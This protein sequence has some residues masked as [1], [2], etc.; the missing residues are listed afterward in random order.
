MDHFEGKSPIEHL[1][2]ARMKTKQKLKENHAVE[3]KSYLDAMIRLMS[4][5]AMFF[6]LLAIFDLFFPLKP[7][8]IFL[9]LAAFVFFRSI[10]CSLDAT[11]RLE[12]L[13]RVIKEERYE[14]E[15][16]EAQ[17]KEELKVM[18]A[19]KGFQGKLLDDVVAVLMADQ[20]RL[21][22]V[23]LEEELGLK[24]ESFEHPLLQGL[25]ALTGGLI[26][27][28]ILQLAII[29]LPL[30]FAIG[31]GGFFIGFS[32]Y[33]K[34][35]IEKISRLKTTVWHLANFLLVVSLFYFSLKVFL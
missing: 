7:L 17:E 35:R 20:N 22:S 1:K 19:Q 23:M 15:H 34:A 9:F 25:G 11:A 14:I 6:G 16:H 3:T 13:H 2:D 21:L 27:L 32:A 4:E 10:Y 33:L 30:S 18:Y 28:F 5:T 26:A 29:F 31:L 24:V 8:L 12:R